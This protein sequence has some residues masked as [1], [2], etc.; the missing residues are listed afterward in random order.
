M[1]AALSDYFT[2]YAD[3]SDGYLDGEL[4]IENFHELC[5][6]GEFHKVSIC[7][8]KGLDPNGVNFDEEKDVYERDDTPLICAAR[9]VLSI[10]IYIYK[11]MYYVVRHSLQSYCYYLQRISLEKRNKE[12]S[13]DHGYFT[14]I[15]RKN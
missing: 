11:C 3:I 13:Q 10:C 15:R 14:Q 4:L 7:L 1:G 12:T 6:K 5:A 9:S 2:S 8:K